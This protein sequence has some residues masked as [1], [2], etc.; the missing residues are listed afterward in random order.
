MNNFA[1][2]GFG[3]ANFSALAWQNADIDV[4]GWRSAFDLVFA[5]M[6]PAVD[7][8]ATL[9]KLHAAS[10]GF[11]FMNGFIQRS[12]SLLRELAERLVPGGNFP[13][14]E[15]SII[16]AFNVLWQHGIF[17]DVVCKNTSWT[18]TWDIPTALVEYKAAFA[19]VLPE[20]G[21]SDA[22]IRKELEAFAENG[23]VTRVMNAKVAW[24]F[25]DVQG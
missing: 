11:C 16:Y 17:A 7:S 8:E 21:L 19:K 22:A 20:A 1:E 2:A 5:S 4:L 23:T 6:S 14:L 25:W 3:D 10:R 15:G 18:N 24:L 12:D 9:M 13:P